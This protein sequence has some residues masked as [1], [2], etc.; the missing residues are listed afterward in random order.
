MNQRRPLFYCVAIALLAGPALADVT[1]VD[2]VTDLTWVGSNGASAATGTDTLTITT[3]KNSNVSASL[4]SS[5][6]IPNTDDQITV[7]FSIT[8]DHVPANTSSTFGVA[9]A[10]STSGGT[11][12]SV[13]INPAGGAQ[14]VVFGE[15]GDSNLGKFAGNVLTTD[16]QSLSFSLTKTSTGNGLDLTAD[17]SLLT[18]S[19]KTADVDITPVQTTTFDTVRFLFNGNAW[20]EEFGGN[21]IQAT[22]TDFTVTTTV[23]EPSSMALA[24][25]G[26][27]AILQRR[28]KS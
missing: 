4:P 24:T 1:V 7:S 23:P 5:I 19:P 15:T 10:D 20:N 16:A 25:F 8:F 14:S 2:S 6:E 12:Y 18:V 17:S 27:L 22:V 9:L 26:L 3:S 21:P 13:L 28:T 11:F